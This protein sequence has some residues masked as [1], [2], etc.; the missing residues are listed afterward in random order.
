[1]QILWQAREPQTG[2]YGRRHH[3][4]KLQSLLLYDRVTLLSGTSSLPHLSSY[5]LRDWEL[6]L[7]PY[8]CWLFASVPLWCFIRKRIHKLPTLSLAFGALF[9]PS[10]IPIVREA[11]VVGPAL[12]GLGHFAFLM[13][14]RSGPQFSPFIEGLL[15]PLVS[16]IGSSCLYAAAKRRR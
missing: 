7:G 1:L 12:V 9:A 15:L 6:F 3:P 8:L 14:G 13:F 10:A 5:T 11:Y 4:L 16:I 2:R